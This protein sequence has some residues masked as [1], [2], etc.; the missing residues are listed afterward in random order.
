M[1]EEFSLEGKRALITGGSTGLGRAMGLVFAEA[2]ADVAI[3]AH[4]L[5]NL[6]A[7]EEQI[8]KHGHKV[9]SIATDVSDS[10]AVDAMVAEATEALGGIDILVNN[11]GRAEGGPVAALPEPPGPET[12][13]GYSNPPEDAPPLAD[14]TWRKTMETNL[15]G[16]FY[17]CRAVAP[18]MMQRRYGKIINIA[19]TNAVLAYPY[20]APYQTSKAGL[21]MF[22]KVLAMEWAQFNINVNCIM[23][24]WFITEMTRQGFEIPAWR[25]KI[26][27]GLPL[28]R[29]TSNR[30]LGLLALYLASPASDWMTGQAIALDGGETA[31]YN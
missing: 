6:K 17:T 10:G 30:D 14:E 28:K 15:N 24:G 16:P 23:P 11:A 21:K 4:T 7:A 25:E 22:T 5:E 19:S 1:I 27:A 31:L 18:Q 3:S 20:A 29:L 12:G 2:G 9:V 13:I 8:S 26:E